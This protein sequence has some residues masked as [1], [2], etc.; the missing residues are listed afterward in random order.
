M[1]KKLCN[2]RCLNEDSKI[3]TW[4]SSDCKYNCK[5]HDIND[6]EVHFKKIENGNLRQKLRFAE[7]GLILSSTIETHSR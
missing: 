6:F 5:Y 1:V 3:W 2:L 4:K 7:K